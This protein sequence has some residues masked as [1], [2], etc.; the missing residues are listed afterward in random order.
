MRWAKRNKDLF[1]VTTGEETPLLHKIHKRGRQHLYKHYN[2]DTLYWHLVWFWESSMVKV[3]ELN[4]YEISFKRMILDK[5]FGKER[6]LLAWFFSSVII[7]R[8]QI[9]MPCIQS[10]QETNGC[11]KE[12]KKCNNVINQMSESLVSFSQ[13]NITVKMTC[14]RR[15]QKKKTC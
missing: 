12:L 2:V 13:E 14:V 4:S 11:Q 7:N 15:G 5:I 1:S 9:K 6:E 3:S 8:S 10:I